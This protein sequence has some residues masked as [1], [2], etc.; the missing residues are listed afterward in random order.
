VIRDAIIGH[1]GEA[2]ALGRRFERPAK[3]AQDSMIAF[4][5]SLQALPTGR[6]T[7]QASAGGQSVEPTASAQ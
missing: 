2:L 7:R 3:F 5:S 1:A 6:R 4:L